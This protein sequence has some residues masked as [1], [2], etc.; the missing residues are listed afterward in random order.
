MHV[1]RKRVRPGAIILV[2][3]FAWYYLLLPGIALAASVAVPVGT[4]VSA[5][6]KDPVDPATATAGQTVLLSVADPVVIGGR[7]VI[8]AGAP[9][10]AEVTVAEKCGAVGKPAK[11][12]VALRHV[13]A[14]DGSNIALSG[15]KQMEG[16][17][18]QTTSLVVTILCCVAGLLMKGGTA[19]IPAGSVVQGT[20]MA[21]A[22][23]VVAE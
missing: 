23:V 12:G 9:V 17:N 15:L 18:K 21:Q 1:V 11:I 6:F 2:V 22:E 7:T 3:S 8:Q 14:V 4:I 5:V 10:F 16:E 19:T 13:T 20:T